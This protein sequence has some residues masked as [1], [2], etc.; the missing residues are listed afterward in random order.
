VLRTTHPG[1]GRAVI[2]DLR[3]HIE[4]AA[5][6][7]LQPVLALLETNRLP[8]DGLADH[9]ATTIVAR[10]NGTIV[11]SAAL[12]V[13]AD[14]ALLRSV[15]VAPEQQGSGLGSTLTNGAIG[16]ARDLHAP[17]VYLLTTTADRYFP[18]F[19]FE[20]IARAEVPAGV[21]ESVE[22]RSACPSSAVVMRKVLDSR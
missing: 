11:G 8:V 13:Y 5:P 6:A 9:L 3:T 15:A 4:R 20:R 19:G 17:A 21:Q 16:L 12:E 7:D 1:A 18:K 14:G 2:G 22:F 10:Q